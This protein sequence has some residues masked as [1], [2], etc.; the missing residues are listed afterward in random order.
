MSQGIQIVLRDLA[1][2]VVQSVQNG[3]GERLYRVGAQAVV[4]L[5]KGHLDGLNAAR[6]RQ[7][8]TNFY[9]GASRATQNAAIAAGATGA[10][11]SIAHV[12]L[13][14]RLRGGVVKAGR[15]T[16]RATGQPTRYLTLPAR[17]DAYR[18][19]AGE[20]KNLEVAWG[21]RGP[22]ALVEKIAKPGT[23]R[24][25]ETEG[26]GAVVYWLRK[27]TTHRADRSV[28]P[29]D[30]AIGETASRAMATRL[31]RIIQQGGGA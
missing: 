2:P 30:A 7:G 11:V 27:E 14:L 3:L 24:L 29:T 21:K 31:A 25:G 20:F 17:A 5:V 8:G 26:R 6:H 23:G 28:L 12:G 9:A 4:V 13:R 15:T 10:V 1:T 16:S 19:R 22:Y 18:K